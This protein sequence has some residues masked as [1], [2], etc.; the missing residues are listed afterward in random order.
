[1]IKNDVKRVL[2]FFGFELIRARRRD[3]YVTQYPSGE[4]TYAPWFT[5]DF[6]QRY[7]RIQDHTLVDPVRCYMIDRFLRVAL[8]HEGAVAECGVY[9]GGTAKLM[10]MAIQEQTDS[11][12]IHLFDSFVGMPSNTEPVRDWHKPGDFADVNYEYVASYLSSFNFVHL[13]KGFFKETFLQLSEQP[14]CF[15]HAD[16]DTY[17]STQ[18]ILDYFWPRCVDGAVIIVDDYGFEQ[19]RMAAKAAVD[20]FCEK[21]NAVN[22]VLPTGQSVLIKS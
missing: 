8:R 17:S 9:R 6:Q 13:H 20:D 21:Y 3:E 16:A 11:R 2:Q 5:V 1:M 15:I 12:P 10:A 7:S 4:P 22:I 14:Y 18:E 19:Y